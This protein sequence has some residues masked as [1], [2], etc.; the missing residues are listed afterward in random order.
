[1][2][3]TMIGFIHERTVEAYINMN[4]PCTKRTNENEPACSAVRFC[5]VCPWNN[6]R[7][8]NEELVIALTSNGGRSGEVDINLLGSQF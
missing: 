4:L 6:H 2:I 1:M 5:T 8:N 3:C 7:T